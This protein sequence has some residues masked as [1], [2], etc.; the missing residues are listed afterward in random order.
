LT[1]AYRS[2]LW[3][4]LVG[5]RGG[6]NRIRILNEL[7]DGPKNAHRLA[8]SLAL[9]YRTIRHHLLLLEKNGLVTRPVGDAYA[10]PYELSPHVSLHFD[11]VEEIR[12]GGNLTRRRPIVVSVRHSERG[13]T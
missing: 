8:A 13:P 10:A 3:Y 12:A 4:L 9:D 5:T 11:V 2:L 7:A 1:D 6:P